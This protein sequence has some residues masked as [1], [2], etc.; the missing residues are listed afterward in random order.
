MTQWKSELLLL[1]KIQMLSLSV[2]ELMISV[3]EWLW[4]RSARSEEFKQD[5][6]DFNA[7]NHLDICRYINKNVLVYSAW[8]EQEKRL[9]SACYWSLTHTDGNAFIDHNDLRTYLLRLFRSNRL[10][11][12]V[13]LPSRQT[14]RK[15][16]A[17][18]VCS[19]P[20]EPEVSI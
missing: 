1:M 8:M 10:L 2:I 14:Y 5:I 3:R 20:G 7:V 16:N 4:R 18:S 15:R 9:P 17:V 19:S 6:R 13:W 11:P 12:S